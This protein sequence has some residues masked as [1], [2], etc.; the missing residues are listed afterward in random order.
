[1]LGLAVAGATHRNVT[2]V[3]ATLLGCVKPL[4]HWLIAF[5]VAV[6]SAVR[7]CLALLKDVGVPVNR[8]A[9]YPRK[10]GVAPPP[11]GAMR[12]WYVAPGTQPLAALYVALLESS[13]EIA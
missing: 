2:C 8:A 4:A 11:L 9:V 6:D 3:L 13:M 5:E 10:A 7:G 12:N 1:M